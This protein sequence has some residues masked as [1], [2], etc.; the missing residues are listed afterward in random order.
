[1]LHLILQVNSHS[2]SYSQTVLAYR[3]K[4]PVGTQTH[5]YIQLDRI[6]FDFFRFRRHKE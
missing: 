2:S 5:V 1:M 6:N 4:I 3:S